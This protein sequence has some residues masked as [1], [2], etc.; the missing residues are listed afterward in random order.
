MT[1]NVRVEQDCPHDGA[2]L[3]GTSTSNR[4]EYPG[5]SSNDNWSYRSERYLNQRGRLPDE[6]GY[7]NRERRPPRRG[8]LQDDGGPPDG[9]GPPDGGGPSD[10]GGPLM[11]EDPLMEMEDPQDAL[12]D[13]DHQDLEDLL[14]L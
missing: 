8:R 4:R 13:E 2:Y 10:G 3:Q 14:D 6:G 12:M 7:P 5:D 11:V 9:V 1:A